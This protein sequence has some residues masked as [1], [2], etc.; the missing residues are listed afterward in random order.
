MLTSATFRVKHTILKMVNNQRF[1]EKYT[2]SR[3]LFFRKR[4]RYL[5]LGLNPSAS[6]NEFS[7][8]SNL[9]I[10]NWITENDKSGGYFLTNLC[11]RTTSSFDMKSQETNRNIERILQRFAKKKIYVFF[12]RNAKRCANKVITSKSRR[13]LD[14]AG[15]A[16]RLFCSVGGDKKFTHISRSGAKASFIKCESWEEVFLVGTKSGQKAENENHGE[17]DES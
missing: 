17:R 7:D 13:I 2:I 10:I 16:G 12:G 14:E 15:K 9:R 8:L 5:F 11:V 4:I 3:F 1:L 6:N